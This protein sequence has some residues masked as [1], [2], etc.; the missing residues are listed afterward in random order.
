[1][2]KTLAQACTQLELVPGLLRDEVLRARTPADVDAGA[3]EE[4]AGRGREG[5]RGVVVAL[6]TL[7]RILR[8]G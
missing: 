6:T 2:R 1:M 8:C 5:V 4:A 7:R 3:V